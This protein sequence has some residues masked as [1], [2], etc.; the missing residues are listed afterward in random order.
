VLLCSAPA[1]FMAGLTYLGI[2][3]VMRTILPKMGTPNPQVEHQFQGIMVGLS[4]FV[5]LVGPLLCLA[6]T[7]MGAGLGHLVLRI[8]GITRGYPVTL[9]ALALS[10]APWVLGLVPFIGT[11]VAPFWVL[12]ACVFAY[13]GLHR[14]SW[15]VALAGVL[16]PTLATCCLF[17]GSYLAL[18]ALALSSAPHH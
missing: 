11:Q 2:F 6:A 8:G 14:T 12:V 18:L 13:R 9:R 7:V 10:Q 4:V 1:C 15:G 17:G 16:V 3:S 5:V